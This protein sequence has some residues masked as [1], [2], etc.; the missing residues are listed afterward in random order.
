MEDLKNVFWWI[1]KNE[2]E[3]NHAVDA[4][5]GHTLSAHKLAGAV[6]L[7]SLHPAAA[8]GELLQPIHVSCIAS[9]CQ[10]N[11]WNVKTIFLIITEKSTGFLWLKMH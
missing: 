3:T 11:M 6:N 7:R 8:Q 4:L 10:K 2:L 5:S 9:L 1:T